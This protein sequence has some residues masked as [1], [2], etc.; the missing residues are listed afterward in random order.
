MI[1]EEVL[2]WMRKA[3]CIQISFGVESGSEKIRRLFNKS[4]TTAQVEQAFSLTT[5]YGI[6]SRAYFIY[7]SPGENSG[8]IQASI[9]LMRRIKPLGAVFYVLDLFP[10]TALYELY[11]RVSGVTDDIWLERI[12]DI[13]YYETDPNL[14]SEQVSAFGRALRSAF[15]RYLP[16]FVQNIELVDRKDLYRR[17]AD[18]LSRLAMTFDQGGYAAIQAIAGKTQL[19]ENL[20]HKALEF[21]PDQRAYLGL[22]ILLQKSGRHDE[23]RALLEEALGHFP[24]HGHLNISLGISLLKLG[25]V[26]GALMRLLPYRHDRQALRFIQECYQALGNRAAAAKIRNRLRSLSSFD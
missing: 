9:K 2:Y 5:R 12:E 11:R 23:A 3:G 1:S 8:T 10:G 20:Y 24:S 17:H 13:L 14:D 18:F 19:A 6:L 22:A 15:H 4:F 25:H 26:D 7:G 16:E 21:H